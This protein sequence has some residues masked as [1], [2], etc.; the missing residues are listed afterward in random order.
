MRT[1]LIIGGGIAGPVAA[2][3]LQRAGFEPV[4]FEAYPTNAGHAGAFL[5]LAVNGLDALRALDLHAPVMRLG[6]PTGHIDLVSGT[7]KRLGTVPI[8]G[9]R[10]DGTM[11]HTI[12]RADLYGALYDAARARGVRIEHGRRLRGAELLADG[13]VTARFEDGTEATGDLLIG[14]DGIHSRTRSIIDPRAPRPRPLGIGNIGGFTRGPAVAAPPGGYAMMFGRRAFFGYVV[15]PGGEIWWF[16][17]PP[18]TR[19]RLSGEQWKA[20]LI[21]LFAADAGP[22]VDIIRRTPHLIVGADQ[23]DMPKVRVWWRGAMIIIGDAAHAASPSSGQ[24]ASLAIEDALVLAKCLRDAPGPAAAFAAFERLRRPRV[25]R[26]VAFGA[27]SASHK[28][29][30][31]VGRVVRDLV[32]PWFLKGF[33]RQPQEWLFGYHLD[34]E[35]PPMVPTARLLQESSRPALR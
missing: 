4:V 14:A 31:P 29:P 8:G 24:G 32:L 15:D 26:V 13:R 17:N 9:S 20:R 6:F 16:A 19:D 5:T 27:R 22:A 2:V 12:K 3:A 25:E 33:A 23:H 30:G 11:T 10:A 18:S 1:A 35:D 7:G 34:W 21:D 28:A